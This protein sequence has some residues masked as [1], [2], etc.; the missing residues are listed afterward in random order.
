VAD[1]SK[2]L[3]GIRTA[4]RVRVLEERYADFGPVAFVADL[5]ADVQLSQPAAFNVITGIRP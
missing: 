4:L 3:L 2:F 1:W 5:R